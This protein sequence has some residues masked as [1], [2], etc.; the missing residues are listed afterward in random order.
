MFAVTQPN[1]NA[2][3]FRKKRGHVTLDGEG[4]AFFIGN[5]MP[6]SSWMVEMYAQVDRNLDC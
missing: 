2:D 1:Q 3:N 4:R 6:P 5:T